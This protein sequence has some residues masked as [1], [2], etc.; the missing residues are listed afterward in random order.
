MFEY[1]LL[2]GVTPENRAHGRP[3]VSGLR[4]PVE[5]SGRG[6]HGRRVEGAG[7]GSPNHPDAMS[8]FKVNL[9]TGKVE[10]RIKTG[11]LVGVER[12]DIKT[13]GG[14][15]PGAVVVGR[16]HIYVSNATNDSI[17]IVNPDS[18]AIEAQIELLV[19]ASSGCAA[20]FRSGG[21]RARRVAAVRRVRRAERGRGGRSEDAASSRATSRR[22]GSPRSSRCHATAARSIVSSAKGL[23][24]GRNGGPG[25]VDA[26]AA[27]IPATSCRA[28]CRSCGARRRA[29]RRTTRQVSATRT[30]ARGA[31]RAG[32]VRT[33]AYAGRSSTSS[34]W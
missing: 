1:P 31:G 10:H 28:R 7:L 30:S 22:P 23:G 21:A 15:S 27:C 3:D 6:H 12:D 34:S 13:V 9:Q 11:Y 17:S 24:S 26:G 32:S 19:P 18:G 5:G 33:A 4:R 14:A 2:P 20:C 16:A 29:A 8:V 25:F